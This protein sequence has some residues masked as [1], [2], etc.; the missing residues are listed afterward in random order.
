MPTLGEYRR[1]LAETAGFFTSYVAS[2]G[3]SRSDQVIIADLQ[4]YGGLEPT[5]LGNTWIYQPNGPNAGQARRVAYDGLDPTNGTVQLDRA[6]ANTTP[7]GTVLE[8]YGRMPPISMEG[9]LGLNTI[10]NRVLDECWTVRRCDL[11]ATVDAQRFLQ[12][13]DADDPSALL[14]PWLSE[15][16]RIVDVWFQSEAAITDPDAQ[17]Q[18]M[19]TWRWISNAN[20]PIIQVGQPLNTGDILRIEAFV[21]MSWWIWPATATTW[22]MPATYTGLVAED[23]RALIDLNGMERVGAA[24]IY[25]ELGKWGLP[26]DQA[27][28]RQLASRARAGAN[29]WKRL[30]LERKYRRTLHWPRSLSVPSRWGYNYGASWGMVRRG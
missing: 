12:L 8:V 6:L 29:Q 11:V 20:N 4:S 19:T 26:D 21:P 28:Y 5:F 25:D 13:N 17:D 1:R 9:R 22:E 15:E 16:D 24:Y 14:F 7:A 10:V 18:L 27:T 23:D 2:A 3:S 30:T